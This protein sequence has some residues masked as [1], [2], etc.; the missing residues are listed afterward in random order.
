MSGPFQNRAL[1]RRTLLRG[2]GA[3]MAL[4]WL[5]AM[6]PARPRPGRRYAPPPRALFVF[7]PNGMKMDD[8]VPTGDGALGTLP[9]LLQPLQ[10]VRKMLTVY[11]GLAI[12]GARAHGDGAGDHARGTAAFLTCAHPRKTGGADLRVGVSV[13]QVLAQHQGGVTRFPSLEVGME[14]GRAAGICDSGYSCAYSNNISW[15]N[16]QTPVAKETE[17]RA[18]FA[19]LFGD[20]SQVLDAREREQQQRRARSVLDAVLED[21]RRLGRELGAGDRQKLDDYLTAVRE[22]EQRLEKQSRRTEPQNVPTELLDKGDS[23]AERLDAMYELL[24]LAFVADET[25]VATF[26]LGNGGSNLSYPFLDVP[27]GHHDLSHHG[28]DP[29][30]LRSIRIIN[31]FHVERLAAFAARLAATPSG[32]GDLLQHTH[33]VF[34]SGI[35]DGDHHNHDDLPVLRLGGPAAG[36]R[37]GWHEALPRQTPMANLYLGVLQAMGVRQ[38][39]FADSTAALPV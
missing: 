15:R 5:D 7:S 24:A 11:S 12:D 33:I 2:L 17:P 9:Y 29:D 1:D 16:E 14:R 27:R 20:P 19:R 25:R 34:G 23:F 31:R 36:H 37:G 10:P 26:M 28:G 35:G 18:V 30:K 32:D 13:D 3:A 8:W 21:A 4:P 6:V 39:R 22:L 38:P